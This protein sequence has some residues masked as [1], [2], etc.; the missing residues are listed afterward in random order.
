[1]AIAAGAQQRSP[2]HVILLQEVTTRGFHAHLKPHLGAAGFDLF[3]AVPPDRNYWELVAY[4]PPMAFVE[5]K[6]EPLWKTQFGRW[7]HT[8]RLSLAS[9]DLT[10]ITA[11]FDSGPE[12]GASA[13]RKAQA[14]DICGLL[15]GAALFAGD[16]NLRDREWKDVAKGLDDVTDV[17]E[18]AG[19]APGHRF[20][21]FGHQ[22][23]ARF[24]RAW[25]GPGLTVF[26]FQL[27][28]GDLET[29]R[30]SPS[31]HLGMR[32]TLGWALS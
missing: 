30:D 28:G 31:D 3:P 10:I 16:T 12:P 20:T 11:H 19:A 8:V 29:G 14:R 24:D 2:P 23:K 18:A 21:W 17:W 9:Q 1:E 4:R 22:K 5:G 15:E 26:D 27:F 13:A 7:M 6:S 25:H 32:L